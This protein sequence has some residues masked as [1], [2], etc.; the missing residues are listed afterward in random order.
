RQ[1]EKIPVVLRLEG[2]HRERQ[3]LG[4]EVVGWEVAPERHQRAIGGLAADGGGQAITFT[5]QHRSFSTC[6]EFYLGGSLAAGRRTKDDGRW[7]MGTCGSPAS[8]LDLLSSILYLLSSVHPSARAG[9][10]AAAPRGDGHGA[11]LQRRPAAG[12]TAP[13]RRRR[14]AR[15]SPARP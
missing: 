8:I 12:C 3:L 1:L 14:S 5:H 15:R 11:H 9:A 4:V 2:D 6:S 13:P 7:T 10:G